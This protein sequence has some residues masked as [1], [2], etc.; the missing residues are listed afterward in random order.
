MITL[1][2][3]NGEKWLNVSVWRN[4]T[5]A[6]WSLGDDNQ[7]YRTIDKDGN[8]LTDKSVKLNETSQS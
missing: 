7:N 1:Q 3:F 6:W 4:E 8:T 2:Y 5:L